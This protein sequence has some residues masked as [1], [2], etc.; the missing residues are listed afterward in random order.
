MTF[1]LA[2]MV[3][4]QGNSAGVEE[5]A[6]PDER[7]PPEVTVEPADD[8]LADLVGGVD[9]ALPEARSGPRLAVWSRPSRGERSAR[10]AAFRVRPARLP[11][12]P[13]CTNS[14]R[15]VSIRPRTAVSVVVTL[16]LT[17]ATLG[18]LAGPAGSEPQRLGPPDPAA[19]EVRAEGPQARVHAPHPG[20]VP[21]RRRVQEAGAPRRRQGH[22]LRPPRREAVRRGAAGARTAS[23]ATST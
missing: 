4:T 3:A 12:H 9:R 5:L 14:T 20:R 21:E 1:Q 18:A 16:A 17:V 13:W 11:F 19:R 6:V 23:R 10:G 8:L 15:L 22:G 7:L 2:S